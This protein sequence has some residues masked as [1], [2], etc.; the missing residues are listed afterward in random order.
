M[1]SEPVGSFTI[2]FVAQFS[3]FFAK[4]LLR[5]LE[6]YKLVYREIQDSV[7]EDIT[8]HV[9]TPLS[10]PPLSSATEQAIM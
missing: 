1:R 3:S 6:A 9:Q 2:E 4:S 5:N 10:I 7:E 8:I